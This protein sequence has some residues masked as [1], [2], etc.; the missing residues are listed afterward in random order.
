[1]S[2]ET[3][4][5]LE[6][7]QSRR[8]ILE[9][10]KMIYLPPLRRFLLPALV[11]VTL[12]ILYRGLP[13]PN[14]LP[15]L[16]LQPPP[17]PPQGIHVP[18][19]ALQNV[20]PSV[21]S[22]HNHLSPPTHFFFDYDDQVKMGPN[23]TTS[24]LWQPLLD[25]ELARLFQCPRKANQYTGHIRLPNIVRNISQVPLV[26]QKPETRI[27]W[28]P[29]I[30][31]LPYWSENQY[32]VVSRI[33]TDGNHQDN[34][35]CE[36]NVCYVP[37][38]SE[39]PGRGEKPCT[40]KD[41]ELMGPAGGMRCAH[42]PVMLSVP[43][44]PA[45]NCEG[46][47][48]TSRYA[49]FG[50][51]I[52]D[53]RT[54]YP[55]LVNLLSSSPSHFSL[56]GPLKSYPTLTEITR[57]P[58]DT[59][60]PIEKNWMLF[61]PPSGEAYV[62]Y[63][64][65]PI[66]GAQR[67]RTFAKLLGNGLTTPNLTDPLELPCLHQ[68]AEQDEPD[69]TKHGGRWHQASNALRLVL[70]NRSDPTCKVRAENTVFF[71][72]IH[73][74]FPNVLEL[75][76]RYERFFMVWSA[77]RP[78]GMVGVSKFPI[79][80]ANETAHGWSE[81]QNW[82][83]DPGNAVTVAATKKSSPTN[84]TEPYGGKGYWAYFTY[85][86]SIS[87]TWG[88]E[89]RVGSKGDESEDMHFGYLDDEVILGIGVD[90]SGQVFSK[91]KAGTLVECLRACPGRTERRRRREGGGPIRGTLVVSE[92]ESLIKRKRESDVKKNKN[93]PRFYPRAKMPVH[94]SE[95]TTKAD[96]TEIV[97]HEPSSNTESTASDHPAHHQSNDEQTNN[98]SNQ[99][100]AKATAQD[101]MSKGPQIPIN[102]ND[103]PPK[104]SREE[105]EQKMKELNQ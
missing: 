83:D 37:G 26:A 6:S 69:K 103:M 90:D 3:S 23:K 84:L 52:I 86:V 50:L 21:D 33:V 39:K 13:I 80:M 5:L 20:L 61:F 35:L 55:P 76:L 93:S 51:W 68:L 104:A 31:A 46:K 98:N 47:Y 101:H 9:P 89:P 22:S 14:T 45:E 88:R 78:Y 72:V 15:N 11:F 27:F 40:P 56:G 58:A 43:P 64:L 34:V 65:P 62:H 92:K 74:K 57:N 10:C 28:N 32:L 4:R 70:C 71:A 73:R 7:A 24:A 18:L 105:T 79:L 1:M 102:M 53:L 100:G 77:T 48:K 82:D 25:P 17:N 91:V 16:I 96:I 81:S 59:R 38:S 8:L 2:N 29:T 94:P 63:D 67:G 54:L 49:C 99:A 42:A 44:T 85:T 12:V 97:A 19:S 66:D 87:Y 75:P 41:L 95:E 36:A 30:I 60:A